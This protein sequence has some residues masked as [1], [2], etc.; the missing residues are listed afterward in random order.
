[1]TNCELLIP[2]TIWFEKQSGK[3]TMPNG[4][5]IKN[6]QTFT[7]YGGVFICF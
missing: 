6:A 7:V 3:W 5:T 2:H 4:D 1:M